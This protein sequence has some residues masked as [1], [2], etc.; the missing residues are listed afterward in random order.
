MAQNVASPTSL[1]RQEYEQAG[2]L[3]RMQ[4]SL[5]Q[6]FV[7]AQARHLA[8]AIVQHTPQVRFSLPDQVLG[9]GSDAQPVAVPAGYR[10]QVIGMTGLLDR[11]ARTD[12]R[13]ALVQ[14]LQELELASNREVSISAKLLRHAT[15]IYMV[16][17]MLPAGRTVRYETAEGE[18][19]PTRPVSEPTQAGSA[20]TAPTDAIAEEGATEAGRGEL[21]VPYAEAARKFYL[22]QW[23]AFDEHDQLLVN[24]A[25]DAEAHVASMQRYMEVLHLTRAF[26]PYMVADEQYQQKRYGLLGQLVNQGR[27]LARYETREIIQTI[28]ERAARHDLNRGLSLSVPYFDDQTLTIE[29]DRFE[30]IPAGRIMF[31][32]AFVVLAVREERA[33][34]TEDTRLNPSTR[35]HLRNQLRTLEIAFDDGAARDYQ[36]WRRRV[37]LMMSSEESDGRGAVLNDPG[38]GSVTP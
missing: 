8:D 33:K 19:I 13:K 9:P 11:L 16:H 15:A 24:A 30:V 34:I 20:I 7:E 27:A 25:E 3:L 31:V 6:R 35:K 10:E 12:V 28:K 21:L 22:P 5:T 18:E 14:R 29:L 4:P 38:T 36:G 2:E 32:P 23:V 37:E 26:T 1:L 17:G